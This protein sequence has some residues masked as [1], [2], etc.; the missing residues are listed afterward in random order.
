MFLPYVDPLQEGRTAVG[1]VPLVLSQDWFE[2][3]LDIYLILAVLMS[4]K[5]LLLGLQA[6]RIEMVPDGLRDP[7]GLDMLER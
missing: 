5:Q 1:E 7:L 6:L 4:F 3:A 2:S